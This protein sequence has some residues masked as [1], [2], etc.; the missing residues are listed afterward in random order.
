MCKAEGPDG[1]RKAARARPERPRNRERAG[2]GRY[3]PE[4]RTRLEALLE[5]LG[6]LLADPAERRSFRAYTLTPL[7]PCLRLNSL[8]PVPA[9]LRTAVQTRGGPVPWCDEA[10]VPPASVPPLGHT[11]E[12]GLGA[13]YIQSKAA[14]L[15][16]CAL[17]PQP[18]ERVLDMAAAPGGKA[19]QIG[20]RMQNTGL[21]VANEPQRK[22]LPALVGN[23]ERCGVANAI[24]SRAPGSLMARDFHNHFDRVLLDAPCSGD[25]ILRKDSSMLHYWSAED[26][27]RVGTRQTGLL[28]AAF[29]MLRPG[30]ILVYSTCSLSTEENEDVLLG[31]LRRYPDLAEILSIPGIDPVPLP[32]AVASRYPPDF[33][34][35]ARVWPHHHDTEGACVVRLRKL[36]ET[37][38]PTRETVR[39]G[40]DGPGPQAERT[41]VHPAEEMGG[42]ASADAAAELR[43]QLEAQWSFEL[44]CPAGQTLDVD[45]R[46]LLLRP[47]PAA[48]FQARYPFWVRAGMRV[49]HRH[50]DHCYLTQQ[51]LTMWGATMGGPRLELKWP[52]VQELFRTRSVQL[53]E[54]TPLKGEVLCS[55]G[56]WTLCR[57]LVR[58][59][60]QTVQAMLPRDLMR[61]DLKKL[62]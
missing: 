49:A 23:L 20:A 15:A 60:D 11:L 31:L 29:H 1:P 25:G 46:N 21:L 43:R 62:V 12:H 59:G 6:R 14:T 58:Q 41:D 16:V 32:A 18:G 38:R 40:T 36:G 13:F 57:G 54:P 9:A 10:L 7:P 24:V 3:T 33:A 61:S 2:L 8:M 53:R 39:F 30:G 35:I 50:K 34:R 26:A 19:T 28:R 44:P 48:E 4:E 52:Q 22:R 5:H 51:A 47:C 17:D 27:C 55:Y 37:E 56:P 42:G 45:R